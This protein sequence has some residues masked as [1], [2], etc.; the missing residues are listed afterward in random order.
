MSSVVD[1]EAHFDLRL[2]ELGL[3]D[4]FINALKNGGIR[5]LSH[6]AFSI[7]Q[8]N[9]VL[10]NDDVTNFLQGL[11]G[12]APSLVESSSTKRLTFE[13]Q[14]YVVATL[15]QGLEQQDEAV[16][17][18]V[19]HAERTTRMSAL[20]LALSGV[21]ISGEL[22]PAHILLDKA[23]AM[24]EQNIVKYIEPSACI[25]RAFEVQGKKES[26]ELS[27]EKGSLVLKA[28]SEKLTSPTDTELKVHYAMQRRALAFQFA[29]LMS[30]A[31]H[32]EWFSFLVDAL[33]REAPPGFQRPSLAQLLQCDR[34]AWTRLASSLSTIRQRA[35]GTYPLGEALLNLRADPNIVLYLSPVAKL[36]SVSSE[37]SSWRAQPYGSQKGSERGIE[38][39]KTKGKGK[40]KSSAP[41][42]PAELRGKWYKNAQ[43]EP[44]CFGYNTAA[45]C[46]HSKTVQDGERCPKGWHLCC[47]PRCQGPHPLSKHGKSGQ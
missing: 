43:G 14:T 41:S 22:D 3:S 31:Q 24:Y 30:Y 21:S 9:Q 27:L 10:S 6:L 20:Q 18:R 40:G 8:P 11:L 25:S 29:N 26:R 28:G 13:A 34:A 2:S 42:M 46:Q 1:S 12:R 39:G 38:K 45:G 33:H 36:I 4:P 37:S 35:D 7:G 32:N 15:R 19:A 17:R 16:P 23:T 47:E 44:L 5:T